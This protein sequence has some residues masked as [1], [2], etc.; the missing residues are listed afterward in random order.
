MGLADRD[1]EP[2][3]CRQRADQSDPAGDRRRLHRRQDR[4]DG[5][6]SRS[7]VTTETATA[8]PVAPPAWSLDRAR[9][10]AVLVI[11]L[12]V[13]GALISGFSILRDIDPFDEGLALQAARRI[14]VGGQV[15][16]GTSS[17]PMV[18]LSRICW[19]GCSSCSGSRC[20]SGGSCARCSTPRSRW[21]R[22][23]WSPIARPADRARLLAGGDLRDGRAP[24]RRPVPAGAAL[25]AAGAAAG[26]ARGRRRRSPA[27]GW[28]GPRC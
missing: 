22:T 1:R 4:T 17:G 12:L 2:G 18:R 7:A 26:H 6:R 11:L 3:A 5:L 15:P 9:T 19:R 24:Q 25:R 28:P 10:P 23:R 14:A 21:P 13:A 16:T 27:V 20:C 8:T